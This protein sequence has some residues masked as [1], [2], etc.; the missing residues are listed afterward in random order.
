VCLT[1]ALVSVHGPGSPP[2]PSAEKAEEAAEEAAAEAAGGGQLAL[3]CCLPL[4]LSRHYRS[5]VHVV[6][7]DTE[8]LGMHV[9]ASLDRHLQKTMTMTSLS[10]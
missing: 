10:A 3:V 6:G 5:R 8:S 2:H 9:A 4:D 7:D 1:W